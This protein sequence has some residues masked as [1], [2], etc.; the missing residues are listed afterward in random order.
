[1]YDSE[2]WGVFLRFGGYNISQLG[3]GLYGSTGL[4]YYLCWGPLCGAIGKRKKEYAKRYIPSEPFL[5]KRNREIV[6][7]S[8]LHT[9]NPVAKT[10]I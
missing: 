5:S 8:F 3:L 7:C 10:K 6:L 4:T 1:M 2:D 9:R